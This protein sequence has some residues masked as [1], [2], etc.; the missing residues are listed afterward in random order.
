MS[1]LFLLL[2]FPKVIDHHILK[3]NVSY[4]YIHILPLLVHKRKGKILVITVKI[5]EIIGGVTNDNFIYSSQLQSFH[6]FSSFVIL[7]VKF[8]I[9]YCKMKNKLFR[10][11]F[12]KVLKTILDF[13]KGK[14]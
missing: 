11:L 4:I 7:F 13:E 3:I 14:N 10:L 8:F 12:S 9:S 1:N 5:F 6:I 2:E